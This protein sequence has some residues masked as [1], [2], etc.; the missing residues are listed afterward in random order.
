MNYVYVVGYERD[1]K[2]YKIGYTKDVKT[3]IVTLSTSSPHKIVLKNQFEFESEDVARQI[4]AKAHDLLDGWRLNGEWFECSLTTIELHIS[5]AINE[6]K[7]SQ[8]T[9]QYIREQNRKWASWQTAKDAAQKP[10][11]VRK[12][13][14]GLALKLFTL[15]G[16]I[17]D[18]KYCDQ[19][20]VLQIEG[21]LQHDGKRLLQVVEF[22]GNLPVGRTDVLR[23]A[24][25][26]FC[27]DY[28]TAEFIRE[29]V[30][31]KITRDQTVGTEQIAA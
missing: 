28:K 14:N 4:E 26:V 27:V 11:T 6:V 2:L 25:D 8:E 21:V 7:K 16:N 3:R 22:H 31:E 17:C 19:S 30:L 23:H 12:P 18:F 13:V 9:K 24:A 20:P 10:I 15:D 5:F 1:Q 29:A